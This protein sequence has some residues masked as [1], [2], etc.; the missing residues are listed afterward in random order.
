[1]RGS[2]KHRTVEVSTSSMADI[3]FLLLSFFLMTTT[4]A[5]EKGLTVHLPEWRSE[6]VSVPVNERNVFKILINSKDQLLV[7]NERELNIENLRQRVKHFVLNN[8]Q[9]KNLSDSP[10]EAIVSIKAD[11]GTT[12]KM[13]MSVLDEVHGAYNEMYA[14]RLGITPMAYRALDPSLKE[15]KL[16][17]DKAK[18]GLPMNVSVA[19][20]TSISSD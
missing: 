20:P 15:Q 8:G 5:N 13:F 7:E 4:I 1:M 14:E 19:E 9:D 10:E 17:I 6:P 18:E 16:R 3:A 12:H 11:R 2:V